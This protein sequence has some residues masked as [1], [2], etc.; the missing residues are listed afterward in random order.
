MTDSPLKDKKDKK[1]SDDDTNYL[2]TIISGFMYGIIDFLLTPQLYDFNNSKT[3]IILLDKLKSYFDSGFDEKNLILINR[4]FYLKFLGLA[5]GLSNFFDASEVSTSDKKIVKELY[6]MILE[7]FFQ[8]K[9]E[10]GGNIL[11]IKIIFRFINDNLDTNYKIN[12]VFFELIE[13]LI[14]DNPDEY[15]SD[16]KNN[17]QIKILLNFVEK[18]SALRAQ[19]TIYGT[20]FFYNETD[21]KSKVVVSC[22]IGRLKLR[23]T[24]FGFSERNIRWGTS[25]SSCCSTHAYTTR[26]L[27]SASC[28]TIWISI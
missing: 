28:G 11:N 17:E 3:L 22:S 8:K 18:F 4:H 12:L 7:K 24:A 21:I 25:V 23:A 6:F 13:K 1:K 20:R 9:L 16:D 2:K 26:W 19:S 5:V 27:V 10:K 14:G 15:F